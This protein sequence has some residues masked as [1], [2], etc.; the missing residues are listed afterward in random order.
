[1]KRIAILT[2]GTAPTA[3][4]MMRM[5]NNGNRYSIGVVPP[6]IANGDFSA[7]TEALRKEGVDF[8]IVENFDRELP[9]DFPIGYMT[10]TGEPD[11]NIAIGELMRECPDYGPERQWAQA[12]GENFDEKRTVPPPPPAAEQRM[13]ETPVPESPRQPQYQQPQ[14]YYQ[15]GQ[16]QPAIP[17][18]E[19]RPMPSNYLVWS[20]LAAVFCC[21]IAGLVA[22]YF[23]S[24]VSSRYYAGN[25]EGALKSSRRAQIWIIVSIVAG[26]ITS[27][28]YWPMMLLSSV[29]A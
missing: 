26:C 27:S 12:L 10:V 3:D 25:Y 23:S 20:I 24:T 1:M 6:E 29:M 22:I 11:P 13:P 7:L 17:Q 5:L 15:Q 2:T 8:L 16:G 21:F 18:Q 4:E 9:E 19:R 14:Y 28:L